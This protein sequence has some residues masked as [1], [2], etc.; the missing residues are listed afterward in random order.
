MS[1]LPGI[2]R[3]CPVSDSDYCFFTSIC[4]LCASCLTVSA[5]SSLTCP[6]YSAASGC[7][8]Y[9]GFYCLPLCLCNCSSACL[10]LSSTITS[11]SFFVW[12]RVWYCLYVLVRLTNFLSSLTL[13]FRDFCVQLIQICFV[14]FVLFPLFVSSLLFSS[15]LSTAIWCLA[16]LFAAATFLSSTILFV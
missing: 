2:Y 10:V 4:N 9:I 11:L 7:S 1:L 8:L 15:L 5:A 13:L 16:F 14:V 12:P 3:S 6:A